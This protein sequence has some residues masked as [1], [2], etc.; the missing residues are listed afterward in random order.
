MRQRGKRLHMMT[1]RLGSWLVG[2]KS[3]RIG[4]FAD[5]HVSLT[6]SYTTFRV[7]RFL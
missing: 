4:S 2:P 6:R 1:I 5:A 7:G 3:A